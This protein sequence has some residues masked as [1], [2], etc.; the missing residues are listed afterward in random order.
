MNPGLITVISIGVPLLTAAVTVGIGIG[1]IKAKISAFEKH[2]KE[3][4]DNFRGEI[5][6]LKEEYIKN[7]TDRITANKDSLQRLSESF[8][9]FEERLNFWNFNFDKRLDVSDKKSGK[10]K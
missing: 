3:M 2:Q 10:R 5:K 8:I 1:I 7:N 6:L 9:R 4:Q